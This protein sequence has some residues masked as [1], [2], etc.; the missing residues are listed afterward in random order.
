[1]KDVLILLDNGHGENTKGKCSPD[2]RIKEWEYT[3]EI[4]NK[5]YTTLKELG[6]DVILVTPEKTDVSLKTRIK[7]VNKYH[8]LHGNSILISIHLNAAG[9]G[10]NWMDANGACV[11]VSNNASAKSKLLAKSFYTKIEQLDMCGNRY[12]PKCKYWIKSLAICR[13]TNCPAILTETMFMDNKKDVEFL[14]SEK[15][16]EKVVEAHV[17]GIINYIKSCQK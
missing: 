6:Y 16:K 5:V 14:L 1:M 12:V 2:E 7:R 13:E 11:Y 8:K 17:E 3:R 4:S 10:N 9:N 15:G